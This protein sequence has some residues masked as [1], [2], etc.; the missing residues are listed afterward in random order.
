MLH[1]SVFAHRDIIPDKMTGEASLLKQYHEFTRYLRPIRP[2]SFSDREVLSALLT[3][4]EPDDFAS[5]SQLLGDRK[6]VIRVTFRT[7]VGVKKLEELLQKRKLQIQM[8][9][10]GMVDESGAFLIVTL[11]NVPQCISDDQVEDEMQ[12]YG[13]VVG[14]SRD[15][16]E[17]KGRKIENERRKVLFTSL[18][19]PS[20]IPKELN[21]FG[22]TVYTKF[23]G[24]DMC[25]ICKDHASSSDPRIRRNGNKDEQGKLMRSSSTASAS[26][27]SSPSKES[28]G[29]SSGSFTIPEADGGKV[30]ATPAHRYSAKEQR[31]NALELLSRSAG[32]DKD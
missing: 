17:Y 2:V 28:G 11:E 21:V 30:K 16:T 15:H 27:T 7:R 4:L 8:I 22:T 1:P 20:S 25:G 26:A 24:Q 9:P 29:S 10:L 12:K 18:N 5:C 31:A 13:T 32:L 3:Y 23:K 6:G 19:D 14:S